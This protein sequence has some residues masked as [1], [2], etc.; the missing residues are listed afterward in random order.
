MCEVHIQGN[1][2]L[3]KPFPFNVGFESKFSKFFELFKFNKKNF[4]F[5]LI[6]SI[7]HLFLIAIQRY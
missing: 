5:K 1:P 2:K 4:N 6:A 7:F 3:D